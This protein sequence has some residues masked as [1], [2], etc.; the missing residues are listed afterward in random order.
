[1]NNR[2][3]DNCG[4][5]ESCKN[6]RECPIWCSWVDVQLSSFDLIPSWRKNLKLGVD[7]L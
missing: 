2:P 7:K 5:I 6:T 3:C 1:M 4:K